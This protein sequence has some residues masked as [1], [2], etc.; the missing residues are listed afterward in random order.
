M[1]ETDKSVGQGVRFERTRRITGYLVGDLERFNNA[2]RAEERERV[3]HGAGN[4][5]H[6]GDP[7]YC[8]ICGSIGERAN[9]TTWRT[10]TDPV[11]QSMRCPVCGN[12][13]KRG[14]YV[15]G[16][17][18]NPPRQPSPGDGGA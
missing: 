8:Q 14:Q 1:T 7:R 18:I 4:E 6:C 9:G 16:N 11:V 2:K 12:T 15:V 3:K 13:W 10:K 17:A 5:R